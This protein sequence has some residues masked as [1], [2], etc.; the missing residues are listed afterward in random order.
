MGGHGWSRH[1][2]RHMADQSLSREEVGVAIEVASGVGAGICCA[3][4]R[5]ARKLSRPF[6]MSYFLGVRLVAWLF[7]GRCKQCYILTI[8]N[9]CGY[10]PRVG[11]TP[12]KSRV[13][14][15]VS[16]R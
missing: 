1:A 16:A 5:M 7:G 15:H 2:C 12:N 4:V 6:W 11:C 8:S 10:N 9:G 14:W 13:S 3:V